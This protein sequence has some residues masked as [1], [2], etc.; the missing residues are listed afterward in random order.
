MREQMIVKSASQNCM[1]FADSNR[2]EVR[3]IYEPNGMPLFCAVDIAVCMGYGAPTK[4][5]SRVDVEPKYRRFVP[6]VSK[7]KRGQS[8]AICFDRKGVEQFLRHGVPNEELESWVL[9]VLIPNA[10]RIGK[11]QGYEYEPPKDD[12]LMNEWEAAREGPP[13]GILER[14][15]SIILEA[16]MLKRE[17]M[18]TT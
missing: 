10:E 12:P 17:I 1:V 3:V 18:K 16:V 2:R 13:P 11:E 8:E 15:D 7:H 4:A 5:V 9:D 6:W 14:L